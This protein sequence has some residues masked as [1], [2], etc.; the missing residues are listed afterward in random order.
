MIRCLAV[1]DEAYASEIIDNY[2]KKTPFLELVGTATNA[3]EALA[4]VKDNLVDVVFLDIQMPE[5]SGLQSKLNWNKASIA[6]LFSISSLFNAF[7]GIYASIL[8]KHLDFLKNSFNFSVEEYKRPTF[9]V[10]FNEIKENYTIGDTI[11]IKGNTKAFA[12][13]NLTNAKV[14]YTISKS[15]YSK[16][17]NISYETNYINSETT[18]DENGNFTISFSAACAFNAKATNKLNITFFI[19]SIL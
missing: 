16:T 12:G 11:K 17:K 18:T 4:L 13:N 9:E 3:F 5:L 14:A 7:K 15:G 19:F 10:T 8:L 6:V 2:I 1:D